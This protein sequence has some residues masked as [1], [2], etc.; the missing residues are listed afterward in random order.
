MILGILSNSSKFLICSR[1]D[2]RLYG[3]TSLKKTL[4]L[5]FLKEVMETAKAACEKFQKTVTVNMLDC[6]T[7]D[8]RNPAP[9][10]MYKTL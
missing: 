2:S 7:V 9:P 8:G 3:K 6:F 10:G 4:V 5:T 1:S